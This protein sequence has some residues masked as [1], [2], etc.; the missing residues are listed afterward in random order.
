MDTSL[1]LEVSVRSQ[2][3]LGP[4][5]VIVDACPQRSLLAVPVRQLAREAEAEVRRVIVDCWR[6]LLLGQ[7]GAPR[8]V[9]W[10]HPQLVVAVLARAAA[11]V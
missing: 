4:T 6:G 9:P 3:S 5:S 7:E 1:L 8:L 2:E 11:K 10:E